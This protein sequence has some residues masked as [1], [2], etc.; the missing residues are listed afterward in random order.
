[1]AT[2]SVDADIVYQTKNKERKAL[3]QISLLYEYFPL[4]VLLST[5]NNF[6]VKTNQSF[7]QNNDMVSKLIP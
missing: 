4:K 6:S 3:T 1:M 5:F 2:L 7:T